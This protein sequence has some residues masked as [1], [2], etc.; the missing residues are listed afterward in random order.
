M[1]MGKGANMLM[2][3][4]WSTPQLIVLARASPTEDV[5]ACCKDGVKD[6][7]PPISPNTETYN[8]DYCYEPCGTNCE[9]TACS[10]LIGT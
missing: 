5:L 8:G 2:T 3:R 10:S 4:R 6:E 9:C 1:K 7:V